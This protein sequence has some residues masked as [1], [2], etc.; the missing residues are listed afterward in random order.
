MKVYENENVIPVHSELFDKVKKATDH[1]QLGQA[2]LL[3]DLLNDIYGPGATDRVNYR[4]VQR[5]LTQLGIVS[6]KKEG[7][8]ICKKGSEN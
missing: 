3:A 5:H 1:V 7:R 4:D 2:F 6:L 8:I